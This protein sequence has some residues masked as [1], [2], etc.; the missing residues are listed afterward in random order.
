MFEVIKLTKAETLKPRKGSLVSQPLRM[1][2]FTIFFKLLIYFI[3]VLWAQF[4]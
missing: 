1:Q 2:A 3:V 4:R